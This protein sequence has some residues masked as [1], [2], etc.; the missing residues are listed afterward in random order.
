MIANTFIATYNVCSTFY[1]PLW[2]KREDIDSYYIKY[3]N[4]FITLKDGR[5]FKI[6]PKYSATDADFEHP[7]TEK[8][9][10]EEIIYDTDEEEINELC[11]EDTTPDN[12]PTLPIPSLTRP[13]P[14]TSYPPY[15]PYQPSS[16]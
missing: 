9:D 14:P 10:T 6:K 5:C 3:D 2:L 13:D 4:L 15:T 16:S 1:I 7:D 11:V 8:E 12:S